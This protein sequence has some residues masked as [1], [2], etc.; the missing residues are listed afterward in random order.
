MP[1][2]WHIYWAWYAIRNVVIPRVR[3]GPAGRYARALGSGAAWKMRGH[4]HMGRMNH[5]N[6]LLYARDRARVRMDG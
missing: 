6:V 1:G 5:D 3:A 4:G 2:S